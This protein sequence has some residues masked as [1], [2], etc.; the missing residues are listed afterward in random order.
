MKLGKFIA[1]FGWLLVVIGF[2]QP[3]ACDMNGA[4]LAKEWLAKDETA[5]YGICMWAVLII[6]IIALLGILFVLSDKKFVNDL[7]FLVPNAICG[8]IPYFKFMDEGHT[9][10]GATMIFTGWVLV[11]LASI[12]DIY[13]N[14]KFGQRGGGNSGKS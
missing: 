4:Q 5:G 6:A 3:V 10:R 7:I 14:K 8:L 11:L 13:I 1:K 2:F 9:Q 12:I